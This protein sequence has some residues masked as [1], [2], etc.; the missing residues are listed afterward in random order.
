MNT[1]I[2]SNDP[3]QE[4]TILPELIPFPN[5]RMLFRN[6]IPYKVP[7]EYFDNLTVLILDKLQGESVDSLYEGSKAGSS[8]IFSN[9]LTESYFDSFTHNLMNKI[10]ITANE[11]VQDTKDIELELKSTS[12]FLFDILQGSNAKEIFETPPYYFNTD[13]K[14]RLQLHV[15]VEDEVKSIAPTLIGIKQG[16]YTYATPHGYFSDLHSRII[17]KLDVQVELKELDKAEFLIENNYNK[18]IFNIPENQYF[19]TEKTIVSFEVKNHRRAKII[20]LKKNI[21]VVLYSIAAML[22]GLVIYAGV[23]NIDNTSLWGGA[24][25]KIAN[26]LSA[27]NSIDTNSNT[28][29]SA[30]TLTID[31]TLDTT[32]GTRSK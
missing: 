24:N 31:N 17:N 20:R 5:L 10:K 26:G 9:G 16:V 29:L 18:D 13:F 3:N 15:A 11:H 7:N 21:R 12:A 4:S 30:D 6:P 25:Y 27:D 32:I 28:Q 8:N 1:H 22:I 23:S 14:N 19:N 2:N